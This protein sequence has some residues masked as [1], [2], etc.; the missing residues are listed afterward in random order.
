MES[1]PEP[2]DPVSVKNDKK[3][4]TVKLWPADKIGTDP[5]DAKNFADRTLDASSIGM[6]KNEAGANIIGMVLGGIIKRQYTE[7]NLPVETQEEWNGYRDNLLRACAAYP[8]RPLAGIWAA[9]PY[10]HNGSV[11]TLYQLLLPP[12]QRLKKFCTSSTDFDP[13]NVGYVTDNQPCSFE[14]DTSITGNSNSGHAFGTTLTHEERL[15]L[16]EFLKDLKFPE[17]G[18]SFPTVE[19][20]GPSC[21]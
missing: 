21:P 2:A 6:D 16:I 20:S 5:T 8:A 9:S 17:A 3:F 7:M 19:P 18:F 10:L 14:L 15:D 1:K 11:P 4:F 12:E 13:V